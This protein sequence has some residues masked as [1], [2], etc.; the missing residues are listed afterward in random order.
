MI[1]T[2]PSIDLRPMHPGE[3]VGKL[4]V[5]TGPLSFWGGVD[6][7]TG[8][9]IDVHHPQHGI[10]LAGRV[11]AMRAGRGSSSGSSVLAE[12]LRNGTGPAAVLLAEP[13]LILSLGIIVAAEVY[14]IHCPVAV[15]S[16]AVYRQ[17]RTGDQARLS[18]AAGSSSV[19]AETATLQTWPTAS[20]RTRPETEPSS[21]QYLSDQYLSSDIGGAG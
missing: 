2:G 11:L 15:L 3:A 20:T 8:A 7:R 1:L 5:L 4:V 9:I 10:E 14:G 12:V 21:A 17:L 16:Y 6:R 13:D 18:A 19:T